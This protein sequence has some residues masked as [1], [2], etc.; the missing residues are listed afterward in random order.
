MYFTG[1]V[2]KLGGPTSY[3]LFKNNLNAQLDAMENIPYNP[4]EP[5]LFGPRRNR[6]D[7]RPNN[8]LDLQSDEN[9][10][11]QPWI[12]IM[13]R[14]RL[15]IPPTPTQ[16][17]L[18]QGQEVLRQRAV[19]HMP[20][21]RAPAPIPAPRAI[22]R[23]AH[24]PRAPAP[25]PAPRAI[26]RIAHVPRAPAPIPAPRASAQLPVLVQREAVQQASAPI[27]APR[28]AIVIPPRNL[29]GTSRQRLSKAM[30][31]MATAS[32]RKKH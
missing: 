26:Q 1:L 3:V 32:S 27:P 4:E 17:P 14:P 23:I 30:K 22:Q 15:A 18:D 13:T 10:N 8:L 29:R 16:I 5:E 20:A 24:V 25:I 19:E 9:E 28:R 11:P 31:K 6:W 21:P 2:S 7:E 12:R